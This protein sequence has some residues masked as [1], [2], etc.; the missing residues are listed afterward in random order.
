MEIR[1]RS[2]YIAIH[3]VV[4]REV[5][6]TAVEIQITPGPTKARNAD[7]LGMMLSVVPVVERGLE[8]RFDIVPDGE[9]P[10]R[11]TVGAVRLHLLTAGFRHG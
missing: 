5:P 11:R 4:A 2:Q 8:G 9:Q 10:L 1:C 7:A 6:R 3:H